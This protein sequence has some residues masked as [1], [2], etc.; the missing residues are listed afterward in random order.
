MNDISET[1][2]KMDS[3]I[4]K[5]PELLVVPDMWILCSLNLDGQFRISQQLF[6]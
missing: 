2:L 3:I 6:I 4:L 5:S 1:K